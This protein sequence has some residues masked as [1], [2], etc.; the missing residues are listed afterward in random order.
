MSAQAPDKILHATTVAL[1]DKAVVI[2]GA[3]GSGKS[4]LALQLM[5]L[6]GVLVADDRTRLSRI[7]GALYAHAPATQAGVI[8]AR[9]V[10]LIRVPHVAQAPVHLAID[11]GQLEPD[12]LPRHRSLTFLGTAVDLLWRVDGPHFP[13]AIWHLVKS[14]RTA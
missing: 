3:S 7:G 11:M 6:G 5:A 1:D 10:G 4:A 8:E 9:G 13:S 12:R 14:G 2:L